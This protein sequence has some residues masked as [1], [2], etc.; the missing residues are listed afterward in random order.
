MMCH[1][2]P[3][4]RTT[5]TRHTRCGVGP[6]RRASAT[7]PATGPAVVAPPP[8]GRRPPGP[9]ERGRRRS[10]VLRVRRHRTGDRQGRAPDLVGE[11]EPYPECGG[12]V[13]GG[14]HVVDE[15]EGD[16]LEPGEAA[17]EFREGELL[18][19]GARFGD[20]GQCLGRGLA[21]HPGRFAHVLRLTPVRGLLSRAARGGGEPAV[22]RGPARR[23]PHRPGRADPGHPSGAARGPR[24]CPLP[25][26]LGR[27]DRQAL[28][29][30]LR[31]EQVRP[32]GTG[33][34]TARRGGGQRRT[35]DVRLPRVRGHAHARGP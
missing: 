24:P 1:V 20:R 21:V 19:Q 26:L 12:D 6:V 15:V 9:P 29:V 8:A 7:P 35:R 32:Q 34:V 11:V 31:R 33:G 2:E 16:R 30:G 5:S 25:Q 13:P 14:H 4:L 10:P 28:L 3:A 23:Q 22:L 17:S 18:F 27:S